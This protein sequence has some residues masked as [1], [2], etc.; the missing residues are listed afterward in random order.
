MSLH[1]KSNRQQNEPTFFFL[2]ISK[3]NKKK[4][5]HNKFHIDKEKRRLWGSSGLLEEPRSRWCCICQLNVNQSNTF[6]A[7]AVSLPVFLT[8]LKPDTRDNRTKCESQV[9]LF[10]PRWAKIVLLSALTCSVEIKPTLWCTAAVRQEL[11]KGQDIGLASKL[12]VGV[13]LSNRSKRSH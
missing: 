7:V 2:K 12:R 13:S 9:G 10:P 1:K 3:W 11:R 5:L 4:R 6:V 8:W